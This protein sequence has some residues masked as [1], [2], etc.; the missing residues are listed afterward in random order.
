MKHHN[1]CSPMKTANGC[2]SALNNQN[3]QPFPRNGIL[4]KNADLPLPI[5]ASKMQRVGGKA[6]SYVVSTVTLNQATIFE[7]TG[8]APNFGSGSTLC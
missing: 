8:S 3:V 5:L 7:Q 2:H 6:Y 1:R 4:A